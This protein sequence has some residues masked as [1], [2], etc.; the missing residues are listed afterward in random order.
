MNT[1]AD[2]VKILISAYV[3]NFEMRKS[4]SESQVNKKNYF[5]VIL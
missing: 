2:S 4:I 5:L 3:N 1:N